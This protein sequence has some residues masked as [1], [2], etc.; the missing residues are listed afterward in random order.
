MAIKNNK[1]NTTIFMFILLACLGLSSI[2]ISAAD[3]SGKIYGLN[4]PDG[5]VLTAQTGYETPPEHGLIIEN[6]GTGELQV[7]SVTVDNEEAFEIEARGA[8]LPSIQAG[9]GISDSFSVKAKSR[10][11]A[12][13]YEGIITALTDAAENGGK[14]TTTVKLTVSGP[15]SGASVSMPNW[16]YGDTPREPVLSGG[17]E[18]LSTSDYEIT[19]SKA[20]V[21]SWNSQKPTTPGDYK[22]KVHVT[23]PIYT[24]DDATA[25]FTINKTDK[26]LRIE[27][28]TSSH[29]YDG[30]VYSDSGYKVYFDNSLVSNGQ[31]PTG[32]TVSGVRITGNVTYVDDNPT[33]GS[34]N[35]IID[36][37]SVTVENL[38]YYNNIK[39][40]DGVIKITPKTQP[41]I[42]TPE[43][44]EKVFDNRRFEGLTYS[45]GEIGVDGH[46][47]EV[48]LKVTSTNPNTQEPYAGS[49]KHEVDSA[50]IKNSEGLDVT[51]CFNIQ[52]QT[53]TLKILPAEQKI[54]LTGT[55]VDVTEN[56]IFVKKGTN[57]AASDIKSKFEGIQ[58]DSA[59]TQLWEAGDNSIGQIAADGAFV[60]EKV[61]VG[62]AKITAQAKDVNGDGSNDYK[63]TVKTFKIEVT[64]KAPLEFIEGIPNNQVFTYDGQP[65]KLSGTPAVS[66]SVSLDSLVI[67]YSG[68]GSTIYNDTNPPTKPG[69]Y[70]AVY[71]VPDSNTGFEGRRTYLFT[72]NKAKFAKPSYG[73]EE[74]LRKTYTGSAI[75]LDITGFN[76]DCMNVQGTTSETAAND[77]QVKYSLK[78]TENC[79]WDDDTTDEVVINWKILKA[80]PAYT[81]PTNLSGAKGDTLSTVEIPNGWTWKTPNTVMNN[82]GNQDFE[83]IFTPE[84]TNNYETV[85]KTVTVNV[86]DIKFIKK[87]TLGYNTSKVPLT[88]GIAYDEWIRR[89]LSTCLPVKNSGEG[90]HLDN[91]STNITELVYWDGTR[92]ISTSRESDKYIKDS[93]KYAIQTNIYPEAGYEFEKNNEKY[94]NVEVWL[95]G[96]KKDDAEI[97]NYSEETGC[98][99]LYIP[100]E[101]SYPE[102]PELYVNDSYVYNGEAQTASVEGFDYETMNISGNVQKNAYSYVISV[103]PKSKWSDGT[104]NAVTTYWAIQKAQPSYDLPGK[105]NGV[106]GTTLGEVKLPKGFSWEDPDIVLVKGS[107]KYA[108]VFTPSDTENYEIVSGIYVEVE[109]KSAEEIV[110]ELGLENSSDYGDFSFLRTGDTANIMYLVSAMAASAPGA[111]ALIKRRKNKINK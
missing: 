22:V 77:Y 41:I 67:T 44:K 85:E 73:N 81:L 107:D 42:I 52:K 55:S 58:G 88:P 16:S 62:E 37:N 68:T 25:N 66:N 23:N 86:R 43:N 82:V 31:L 110:N 18:N 39:Y 2:I 103:T 17:L 60:A 27:A 56:T 105:L 49:Y 7:T 1:R 101:I 12:G 98:I 84:D 57:L 108:T 65:K 5:V 94:K 104:D 53:G 50:I 63:E 11:S 9:G 47:L 74:N 79:S 92:W 51:N 13:V 36:R 83:I 76:E 75:V 64:E 8:L 19:Y 26:E 10:L 93:Q 4:Q 109:T 80:I 3:K 95:N 24:A 21:D 91:E 59:F 20:G 34:K 15:I 87:V 71:S 30:N 61:G 40:V 6:T 89:F 35:N 102:K 45:A 29:E 54:N 72:I 96:V 33:E 69:T 97:T 48:T 70:K 28:N 99:T 14:L 100:I 90:Y 78:D 38:E 111:I 32:D 46:T 106:E